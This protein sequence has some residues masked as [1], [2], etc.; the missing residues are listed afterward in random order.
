MHCLRSPKAVWALGIILASWPLFTNVRTTSAAEG[1]GLWAGKKVPVTGEI[2]PGDKSL[3][4]LDE[5]MTDILASRAIPGATLAV[6]YKGRLI[7][8]RGYGWADIEKHELVRP[9]T[10]FSLASVSKPITAIAI[11]RLA[12]RDQLDL[13]DGVFELLDDL[14]APPGHQLDPRLKQITIRMLLNHSGGWNR[15][16]SGDPTSFGAKVQ[17]ELNVKPPLTVEQLIRYMNGERLDFDPGT[18]QNYSNYG[19]EILGR[20]VEHVTSRPYA[21][22]VQ[23]TVFAP[24]EVTDIRMDK[25]KNPEHEVP[26]LPGAA[27]RYLVG[28]SKP[29]PAG[30]ILIGSAGG[31]C[32]SSVALVR[33]LSAIDGTRVGRKPL[34][35][36]GTFAEMLARPEPPLKVRKNGAWFGLG[37]DVVRKYRN[38]PHGTDLAYGKN[39]GLPGTST[40]IQHL[41]G[42]INWAVFFNGTV[43]KRP[44][45]EHAAEAPKGDALSDAQKGVV[46]LIKN[47][48]EWPEGDL[49]EK[50]R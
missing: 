32:G 35:L 45:A 28:S 12:E 29:V 21:A 7:V 2:L 39:G 23:Q 14:R 8:A 24:L 30:H 49:F 46:D 34:L 50:Y 25:P 37:W 13:D 36:P 38:W 44:A 9:E 40:W 1:E 11:L 19:F 31:W 26:Y 48:E 18:D 16:K 22:Y 6:T 3:R 43:P 27:K 4:Q 47:V 33:F 10:L 20:V 5:L 42:G 41:P 17:K 15:D